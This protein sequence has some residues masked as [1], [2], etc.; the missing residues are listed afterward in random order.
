[1][2]DLL[3]PELV[4]VQG[5]VYCNFNAVSKIFDGA[6][7]AVGSCDDFGDFDEFDEGQAEDEDD[8][9]GIEVVKRSDGKFTSVCHIPSCLHA[10]M[11]GA[12]H[13]V[14]KQMEKETSTQIQYPPRGSTSSNITVAG[15]RRSWVKSCVTRL[16]LMSSDI[17]WR[18]PFTHFV[19]VKLAGPVHEAFD[20][21][22]KVV[23]SRYDSIHGSLFQ[24]TNKLHLTLTT[25]SLLDDYEM[26]DGQELLKRLDLDSILGGTK[27]E[28]NVRGLEVMNDD[29]S[30]VDVL[31]AK[32]KCKDGSDRLQKLADYVV[33]KFVNA[34]LAETQYDRVKLHATLIN[35]KFRP[36]LKG[37]STLKMDTHNN[38][39]NSGR[40]DGGGGGG[41]GRQERKDDFSKTRQSFD[42][43]GLLTSHQLVNFD[44]G[45][46]VI[47]EILISARSN[48]NDD[49]GYYTTFA[50][51]KL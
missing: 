4:E 15:E 19:S 39:N 49:D 5:R 37:S 35:S 13:A 27:L 23:S 18:V 34:Q 28:V 32:V 25:L 16:Q 50:S 9:D 45:S 6:A 30:D 36:G 1:M 22:R 40:R 26:R 20:Q 11:I 17:R 10:Y 33:G 46:L 51:R 43:S 24:E 44:F 42:A 48:F 2:C 14:R 21:F 3:N 7:E 12:K 41:G 38:N 8:D 47:E 31:Y 29:P